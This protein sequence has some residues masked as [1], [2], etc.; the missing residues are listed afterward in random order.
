MI[1]EG[2]VFSPP[3][4]GSHQR[5]RA[6]EDRRTANRPI[7]D[8]RQFGGFI[9]PKILQNVCCSIHSPRRAPNPYPQAR[10]LVASQPLNDRRHAFLPRR[11]AA[12]SQARA[13][14]I[15]LIEAR[16]VLS[17][18]EA[19]LEHLP[20]EMRPYLRKLGV[21]FRSLRYRVDRLGL[22]KN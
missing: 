3:R 15:T 20:K 10:K 13:L 17:R 6:S 16:G 8:G 14:L 1:W 19:G 2:N 4:R 5:T 18:E 12:G 11:A 21:T 22:D 7:Q 9:A